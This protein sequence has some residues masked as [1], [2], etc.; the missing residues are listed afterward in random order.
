MAQATVQRGNLLYDFVV[1]PG[2]ITWSGSV[3]TVSSAEI[4]FTVQGLQTT[5]II[6]GMSYNPPSGTTVVSG[7]PYG[8]S[9]SNA[10]VAAANTLG[11]LWT[12]TT[13][14]SLT[15]PTNYWTVEVCRPEAPG[16]ITTSAAS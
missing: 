2:A 13:G 7:I 3:S 16:F 6:G 1:Q 15:P 14:G 10:R 9:W 11:M 12:N 8:F 5:D 4:T